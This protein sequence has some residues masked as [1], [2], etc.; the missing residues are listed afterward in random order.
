MRRR[1]PF[2]RLAKAYWRDTWV[3]V[4]QFSPSLLIFTLLIITGSVW[5]LSFYQEK[6]LDFTESLYATLMLIFLNPV[7]EFP[8]SVVARLPFF[9]IPVL[10]V[11]IFTEA[12]IRFGILLF[13]KSYRQEEWQRVLASTYRDHTIVVGIGRVGYRVVE[14]LL[15]AG[16]EVVAITLSEDQEGAYLVRRLRERGVPVIVDDARRA[17]VLK[18]GQVERARN[19]LICSGNDLTNLEIALTARE[20]N[21]K[22]RII[23]RLFS[24]ELA[25]R[26]QKFLGVDVAVSTSALAAPSMVASALRQRTAQAFY[27]GE[28]LFHVVELVLTADDP[29]VGTMVGELERRHRVS[30]VLVRKPGGDLIQHPPSELTL[31][32]GDLLVLI[33][34]PEQIAVLEH[35]RLG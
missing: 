11:A 14:E 8:R 20:L 34:A 2:R 17:E 31:T 13:A 3:L 6:R 1:N 26:A 24:D 35:R 18:A 9:V 25:E 33:G 28:H 27:V 32:A 4:C 15:T 29:L 30:V 23:L 5:L 10:G 16:V 21:S 19:L 7:L 12:V 22:I